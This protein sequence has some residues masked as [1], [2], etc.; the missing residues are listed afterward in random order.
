MRNWLIQKFLSSST[1][2]TDVSWAIY[3]AF[4]P[5]QV[6]SYYYL[7]EI[8]I[9]F[10]TY[11]SQQVY[12]IDLCFATKLCL[13]RFL[14]A[15]TSST[16]STCLHLLQH[17]FWRDVWLLICYYCREEEMQDLN[18]AT[19]SKMGWLSLLSLLICLSVSGLQLWH[20]K[21]F[22]EKKKLI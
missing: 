13:I 14:P 18:N 6:L 20:L 17:W 15:A 1:W 9:L 11:S 3:N 2:L 19:N 16:L 5:C 21:S 4:W 10:T 7:Y 12:I 8:T 22:F